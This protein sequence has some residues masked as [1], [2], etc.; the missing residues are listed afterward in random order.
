[1]KLRAAVLI[2]TLAG[3][4]GCS[5]APQ[6]AK[7]NVP[8]PPANF[9]VL[10]PQSQKLAQLSFE[11][12]TQR[13]VPEI[14]TAVGA[15]KLDEEKTDH[16]GALFPGTVM[17]VLANI[18][19]HVKAGQVLAEIHSHDLHDAISAYRI[20]LAEAARTSRLVDYARR[21]RDRYR[22]L[23][24]I[25]FASEQ[26]A[27]RAEMDLR[28]A[29]ADASKA[30]SELQAARAHLAGM[31][32]MPERGLAKINLDIDFI[33][34]KAP[35]AGIVITRR[36]TPGTVLQPGTEA[37]TVSDLSSLWMIAAV[38]EE[39]LRGLRVGMPVAVHVRAYPGDAFAGTI[40]QLG[41]ELDP[42]TR[43]LRVRVL[44]PNAEERLKPE[45]YA[46]AQI[47]RGASRKAL[48]VPEVSVQDLNGNP[49][50]FVRHGDAQFEARPVR[51]G[52]RHDGEIEIVQG[53]SPGEVVAVKGA[54]ILK[55]QL[56]QR[57]L[58]A[59]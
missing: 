45:M 56:L 37:F 9:I 46:T 1:M 55:S 11:R 40:T 30:S 52:A 4:L 18:G 14:L 7:D 58:A 10:A 53:L 26:E 27:E 5:R 22:S 20:A 28:S 42:I 35:R 29:K 39:N 15:V 41:P 50:V 36:V 13:S 2:V 6:A 48:F 49:V 23:Y 21:V 51:T 3:A 33:P 57:S 19:D 17:R 31:L 44:V 34:L 47:D 25:K 8:Q 32:Q 24:R 38:S 43:T 54:F 16:V 12:V 59:E